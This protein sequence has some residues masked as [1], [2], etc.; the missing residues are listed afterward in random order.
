[1]STRTR[2]RGAR[3][4]ATVSKMYRTT[5]VLLCACGSTSEAPAI[6]A[7]PDVAPIHVDDGTPMRRPC[8]NQ[9][10]TGVTSTSGRL[11]GLLV[12]IV[13]PG[14]SACNADPDHLHL[15]LDANGAIYDV[16]INVGSNQLMDVHTGTRPFTMPASLPWAAG[17]HPGV[18][19]NYTS[20]GA[21]AADLALETRAQLVSE[22]TAELA[23]V[24]HVSIY[25]SGYGPEGVHLVHRNNG[26][27]GLLIIQPLSTPAQGRMF[28]FTT[29]SF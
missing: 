25:A 27:D 29:Q 16:A 11:D 17:W 13:P 1:M 3:S 2:A 20:L 14:G 18:S 12:A 28:S 4:T 21:H 19:V 5:L 8:T 7:A 24:N 22:L 6:D 15:Q 10:G 9:F 23:N 26:R